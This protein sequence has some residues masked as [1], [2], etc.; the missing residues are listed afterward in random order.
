MCDLDD[1]KF[2]PATTREHSAVA[3]ELRY[4]HEWRQQQPETEHETR[5]QHSDRAHRKRRESEERIGECHDGDNDGIGN[6]QE[7]EET[8]IAQGVPLTEW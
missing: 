4:P 5:R 8:L 2:W 6:D 1:S 3:V 7:V